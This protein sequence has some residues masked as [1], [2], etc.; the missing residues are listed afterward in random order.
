MGVTVL[1]K[2]GK[3]AF[4]VLPIEDYERLL[5]AADDHA[6]LAAY[7]R[8]RR[9]ESVDAGFVRRLAAGASPSRLWRERRGLT[10]ADLARRIVAHSRRRFRPN[11]SYISQI[12][13][14]R[15]RPSPRL[16]RVLAEAL[17]VEPEDLAVD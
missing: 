6:A 12:E 11:A 13:T 16:L 3:P 8:T 15:R 7:R 10:Q 2:N 1:E 4:A 5:E 9:E 14:G 17:G